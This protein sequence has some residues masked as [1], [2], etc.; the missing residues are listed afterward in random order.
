MISDSQPVPTELFGSE[1]SKVDDGQ[2]LLSVRDLC[3][4]FP[5]DD[6]L[7]HAVEN[8]TFD[9]RANETLGIV[10]ESGSGNRRGQIGRVP[11]RS[12]P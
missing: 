11:V 4:R 6:G 8:M 10:G 5:T 1:D 7:V 12:W 2:T 9:L 3:V